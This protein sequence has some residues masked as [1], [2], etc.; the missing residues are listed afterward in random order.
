[1][2]QNHRSNILFSVYYHAELALKKQTV[3]SSSSSSCFINNRNE[4]IYKRPA[5]SCFPRQLAII[6]LH[7][8]KQKIFDDINYTAHTP[9]ATTP[10]K[11]SV[12]PFT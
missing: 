7:L 8:I 4:F 9:F 6:D 2:A 12:S 1:M 5:P 3:L 11:P 10:A